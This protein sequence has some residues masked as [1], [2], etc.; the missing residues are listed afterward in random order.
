MS[1]SHGG[2]Q[3]TINNRTKAYMMHSVLM[4]ICNYQLH[5]H[6]MVMSIC[7]YQLALDP[8]GLK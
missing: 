4:S 8:W 2:C 7:S 3:Q 6:S 1:Y 5:V